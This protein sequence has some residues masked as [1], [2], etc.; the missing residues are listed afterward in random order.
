MG[1]K[2]IVDT[3]FWT[4]GKVDDFSPEDK[5]FMLYLLTSPFTSLLGIYEISI[6][7]AAFQ[8]G[9]TVDTVNVLLDRFENKYHMIRFSN[10][11]N[12]IAILNFLRHSIIKGGK[13]VKDCLNKEINGVKNKELIL[14]VFS[15]V[16]KYDGL[17]ETVK[18]VIAEYKEKNGFSDCWNLNENGDCDS[19]NDSG[20]GNGYGY[21]VSYPDSYNESSNDTSHDTSSDKKSIACK[22]IVDY[23]NEKAGTKY[24]HTT[25][26]TKEKIHARMSEG[27]TVDNFKTVI[28]KKCDEWIGSDMEKFLRPETLFGPKFEGYLNARISKTKKPNQAQQICQSP[29]EDDLAG[30]F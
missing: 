20:N 23:L 2:R 25:K 8:M 16:E 13:P 24:R 10:K 15:H 4:D 1:L 22:E 19:G 6:K 18:E 12:E 28:D 3:A 21:G 14:Y 17:N 7:Q 27:Y 9:Y 26:N 5:Y 30:I 11:T 29:E